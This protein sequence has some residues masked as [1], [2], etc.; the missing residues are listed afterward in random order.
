M[1]FLK[2]ALDFDLHCG[3]CPPWRRDQ[4]AT[5]APTASLPEGT[6]ARCLNTMCRFFRQAASGS[7]SRKDR[8]KMMSCSK[9]PSLGKRSRIQ[10]QLRPSSERTQEELRR[11]QLP[12]LT[13]TWNLKPCWLVQIASLWLPE[14]GR[15]PEVDHMFW[16][17][18]RTPTRFLCAQAPSFHSSEPQ[19]YCLQ[20]GDEAAEAPN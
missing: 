4:W 14:R 8:E 13:P 2:Y 3:T 10:T 6:W 12:T 7:S 1:T 5:Q 15:R 20:N 16:N 19:S 17:P 11:S 18:S 9:K